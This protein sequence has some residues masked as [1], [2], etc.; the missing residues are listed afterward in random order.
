MAASY[1]QAQ[2]LRSRLVCPTQL[3]T[4]TRC[5]GGSACAKGPQPTTR[6]R[7]LAGVQH[8]PRSAGYMKMLP[9]PNMCTWSSTT[10]STVHAAGALLFPT[11]SYLA[12]TLGARPACSLRGDGQWALRR[13][14]QLTVTPGHTQAPSMQPVSAVAGAA[15]TP[16]CQWCV[17]RRQ[18]AQQRLGGGEASSRCLLSATG[19]APGAH[20]PATAS[21]PY[22]YHKHPAKDNSDTH[23][24]GCCAAM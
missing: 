18:Q 13:L 2:E 15:S 8:S 3:H 4:L 20:L 1:R 10:R 17:L 23:C 7:N 6:C 16:R 14:H 5:A 11:P 21:Q 24:K 19:P 9:M 12:V 22:Q